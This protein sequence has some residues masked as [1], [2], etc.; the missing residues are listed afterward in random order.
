MGLYKCRIGWIWSLILTI[1]VIVVPRY[2]VKTET[3]PLPHHPGPTAPKMEVIEGSIQ[4]PT[5]VA[6]LVDL[7]VPAALANHVADLIKPVFDVRKIRL[8]NLFR[9]EK[10]P[11]GSLNTFEYKIDDERVL[12]VQRDADSYAAKVETLEFETRQTIITTEITNNLFSALD[13]YPK[14]EMLAIDLAQIFASDVDFSSDIQKGDQIRLVVDEQYHK[15]DFVKYGRIQAAQLVNA[16]HTYRAFLFKDSYYDEKGLAVKRSLLRSPLEF[17]RIS[18]GYTTRRLHPILGTTRAHLAIDY[19][20][21]EGAPVIAVANGVVT[22]AGWNTGYGN[23]VQIKH[24]NG[25]TTGYAHLSR[26]ASGVRTGRAIKQGERV[27]AVGHTG[28]ATGP[29]LHYMMTRG[30]QPIN[31]LSIKS[32][33][34]LPLDARLKTEFLDHIGELQQNLSSEV[35]SAAN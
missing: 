35:Q 32:E 22:F 8:G 17:T 28:L 24:G 14:G 4:R 13:E 3:I 26:I 2:W 16:G 27:G 18:S 23:L 7:E 30:G 1:F 31:P 12:K 11:D 19:A 9:L 29:H 25:L 20:A 33:P 10:S 5:L 34:A 21:P 6:T 15:G